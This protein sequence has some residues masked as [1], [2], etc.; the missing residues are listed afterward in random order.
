[1][2]AVYQNFKGVDELLGVRKEEE[3]TL[4]GC[5]ELIRDAI[6]SVF[7]LEVQRS[8]EVEKGGWRGGTDKIMRSVF[9][10]VGEGERGREEM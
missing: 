2:E 8:G 3:M 4:A 5:M 7:V 6:C 9:V 10:G 1:M